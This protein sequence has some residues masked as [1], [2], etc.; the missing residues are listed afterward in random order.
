MRDQLDRYGEI[1]SIALRWAE[2]LDTLPQD[3]TIALNVDDPL[4]ASLAAHWSGPLPALRHR[5]PQ[6]PARSSG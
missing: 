3:A 1:E 6:R 5:R 2:A 4:I